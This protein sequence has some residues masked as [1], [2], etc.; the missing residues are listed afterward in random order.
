M[1]GSA[2]TRLEFRIRPEAKQRIVHAADLVH[3]SSSDFVRTAAER[4]AD[5]V[6]T[7][8][9]AVTIVSADFFD[10][11]LLALDEPPQPNAALQ[12]AATRARRVVKP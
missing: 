8:H 11:M 12:R 1:S 5:E 2:S 6:L 10:R 3:E 4:R 7:E 9:A